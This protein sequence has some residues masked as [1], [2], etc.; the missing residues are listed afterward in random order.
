VLL[1]EIAVLYY[2]LFH[3]SVV[4][5]IA[6]VKNNA[7]ENA[8]EIIKDFSILE[9]MAQAGV[10]Y[11]RKKAS[12]H[13]KMLGFIQA[14]RNG[15]GI[16]DLPQTLEA[17]EKAQAFLKEIVQK[18]GQVLLVGTQPSAQDLIKQS[19]EKFNFP[20]VI[21]RW[22]GGT[23][24]NFKTLSTRINRYLQLKADR[25]TGKLDKYTKKERLDFDREIDRMERLFG[26]LDNMQKLPDAVLLIDSKVHITAL[27]EA[28]LLKI[29]VVAVINSDSDP[30]FVQYPIPAN[31]RSK[32]S[33]QWILAK[34]DSAMEEGKKS[35][36]IANK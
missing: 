24:T 20:Y 6:E 2:N 33:V 25:A 4:E 27:K 28:N 9:E 14:V 1:K 10:L 12:T 26:G 22:L 3:M 15:V 29:P 18:G 19:S 13:P 23:L 35:G 31:S 16:F 11:G 7:P 17:V 21:Q 5:D 36:V 30:D 34:L 8:E 32:T